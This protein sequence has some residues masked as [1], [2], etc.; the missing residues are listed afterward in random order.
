MQIL[1]TDTDTSIIR[2]DMHEEIIEGILR[3][4]SEEKVPAAIFSVIG[5]CKEVTLS[6]YNLREKRYIDKTFSDLEIVS[7][8]GN[9]GMMEGK[10]IIHA[11]GVFSDKNYT[12]FGGHIKQIIISATGEVTLKKLTGELNRAFDETTGLNLLRK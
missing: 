5:A 2:F 3:Y 10:P 11:H 7:V 4:A 12:T 6:Y 8:T 1:L 9:M